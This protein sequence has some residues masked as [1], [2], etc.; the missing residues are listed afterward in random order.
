MRFQF[1]ED[2][3]RLL[4]EALLVLVGVSYR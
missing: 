2:L 3:A 1:D 4:P